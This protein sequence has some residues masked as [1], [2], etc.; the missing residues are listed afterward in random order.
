MKLLLD[1]EIVGVETGDIQATATE[2]LV[3]AL[4]KYSA[5]CDPEWK[6]ILQ[7]LVRLGADVH[8]QSTVEQPGFGWHVPTT[9]LN[10]LVEWFYDAVESKYFIDEWLTILA[11]EGKNIEEYISAEF[12][13]RTRYTPVI[14]MSNGP[15]FHG[16]QFKFSTAP[17][18]IWFEWWTDPLSPAADVLEQF[19][20]LGPCN[21]EDFYDLK[22]GIWQCYPGWWEYSW[23][24]DPE[25]QR[26]K[27][28]I[29]ERFQRRER[30]KAAKYYKAMGYKNQT[31][32]QMPG[33]WKD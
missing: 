9:P 24:K 4:T 12:E 2:A 1:Q 14:Y 8:R 31:Q 10:N 26:R 32:T 27:K 13:I 3:G 21:S 20:N 19:K 7:Q 30:N 17:P 29:N 33:A 6:P 23:N 18:S 28:L 25:Y 22:R 15:R 16:R 11:N 5:S